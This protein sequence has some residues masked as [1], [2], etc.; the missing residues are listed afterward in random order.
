[1]LLSCWLTALQNWH[2]EVHK[3]EFILQIPTAKT[4]L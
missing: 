1:M 4:S 2:T 3:L